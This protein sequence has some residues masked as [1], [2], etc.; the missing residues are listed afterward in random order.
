MSNWGVGG[1]CLLGRSNQVTA[2]TGA[3]GSA[4]GAWVELMA[5][6]PRG[7]E[8]ILLHF[9]AS[10]SNFRTLV[11]LGIGAAGSEVEIA[12]DVPVTFASAATAYSLFLP[13][14]V[15]VGQRLAIRLLSNS[16]LNTRTCFVELLGSGGLTPQGCSRII[17]YG[18]T[19]GAAGTS[20]T[21]GAS[22]TFGTRVQIVATTPSTARYFGVSMAGQQ[23]NVVFRGAVATYAGATTTEVAPRWLA[24]FSQSENHGSPTLRPIMLPCQIARGTDLRVAL[25]NYNAA[26]PV[27]G[28]F[29]LLGF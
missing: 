15:P 29:L 17:G 9:V 14:R 19:S 18:H 8:G 24:E 20:V 27:R 11:R 25:A 10:S 2:T 13:L 12:T 28:V 4:F 16:T 6:V 3:T 23:N 26:N 22:G 7:V 21:A 5:A 1:A